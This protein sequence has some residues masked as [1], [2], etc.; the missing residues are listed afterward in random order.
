MKVKALNQLATEMVG[1]GKK[2]NVFFVTKEGNVVL[3]ALDFNLAYHTWQGLAFS[4]IESALE[5]RATGIIASAGMEPQYDE[6]TDDFTGPERWEVRDD[7]RTFGF[8]S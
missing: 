8:R 3:I 4:H 5:D 1:D 2:Q 6:K 7:S